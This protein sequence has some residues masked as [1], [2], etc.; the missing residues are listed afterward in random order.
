MGLKCAYI[1]SFLF[2]S[3]IFY[4]FLGIIKIIFNPYDQNLSPCH[5]KGQSLC[6]TKRFSSLRVTTV[7]Y[8]GVQRA[9]QHSDLG[10]TFSCFKENFFLYK[11]DLE[12]YNSLIFVKISTVFYLVFSNRDERDFKRFLIYT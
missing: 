7:K 1:T 4:K 9:V 10:P 3:I 8:E 6:A 12:I 5:F 2:V 11:K